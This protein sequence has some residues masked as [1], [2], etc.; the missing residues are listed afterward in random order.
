MQFHLRH[1][2]LVPAL[3]ALLLTTGAV[4]SA[5]AAPGDVDT[6]FNSGVPA[7][8]HPSIGLVPEASAINPTNG[9]ILWAGRLEQSPATPSEEGVIAIYRSDGTLET[10]VTGGGGSGEVILGTG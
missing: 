3:A 5:G 8:L 4:Q 1:R 2:F 10:S 9:D 6:G 7:V